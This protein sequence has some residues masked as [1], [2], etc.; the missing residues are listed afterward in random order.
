[1]FVTVKKNRD[2]ARASLNT[3]NT[4]NNVSTSRY[5]LL[6]DITAEIDI[7]K[8]VDV[9]TVIC[10]SH[11]LDAST[12]HRS[13]VLNCMLCFCLSALYMIYAISI[14]SNPYDSTHSASVRISPSKATTATGTG[15][16]LAE[17]SETA[18]YCQYC[19]LLALFALS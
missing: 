16:Q 2:Q 11:D 4:N 13:S 18:L 9:H 8:F 14:Y 10:Q 1:M 15:I 19:C 17:V 7:T 12:C 6:C 5:A 3:N